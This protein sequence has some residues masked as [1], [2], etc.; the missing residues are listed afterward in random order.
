[1][2]IIVPSWFQKFMTKE[3]LPKSEIPRVIYWNVNI[4]MDTYLWYNILFENNLKII[5]LFDNELWCNIWRYRRK[6]NENAGRGLISKFK[7]LYLK[8]TNVSTKKLKFFCQGHGAWGIFIGEKK[9]FNFHDKSIQ[10]FSKM[11]KTE[12]LRMTKISLSKMIEKFTLFLIKMT[13]TEKMMHLST[14]FFR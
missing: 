5:G 9:R 3:F 14:F 12:F 1:M 13:K 11:A 10:Y 8:T 4:R 2:E 7:N 6:K